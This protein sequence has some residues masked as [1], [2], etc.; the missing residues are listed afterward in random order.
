MSISD[1]GRGLRIA[2]DSARAALADPNSELRR[3]LDKIW[4]GKDIPMSADEPGSIIEFESPSGDPRDL[5]GVRVSPPA[6]PEQVPE[7]AAIDIAVAIFISKAQLAAMEVPQAAALM[8]S[9]QDLFIVL[10]RIAKIEKGEI[11]G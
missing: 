9:L 2:L 6:A 11:P 5:R 7:D 10:D 4:C 1:N 3:A 8:A